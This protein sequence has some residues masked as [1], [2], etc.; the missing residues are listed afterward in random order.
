MKRIAVFVVCVAISVSSWAGN[1]EALAA[2]KMGDYANA[3]RE[4]QHMAEQGDA[5][6]QT[7]LGVMYY[8][9]DGVP[10]S[11]AD[12]L[13]WYTKAAAQ[14]YARA[15]TSLGWMYERG[16][17]VPRSYE[18]A[19]KWYAKAAEQGEVNAQTNLGGMYSLGEGVQQNSAEAVKWYTKA[20]EQGNINAQANLG[21]L[22]ETGMGNVAQDNAEAIKWYAKA[23]AQGDVKSQAKIKILHP[24]ESTNAIN[25]GFDESSRIKYPTLVVPGVPEDAI[26]AFLISWPLGISDSESSEQQ[27]VSPKVVSKITVYNENKI[28]VL[29][30][31]YCEFSLN[32]REFCFSTTLTTL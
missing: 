1:D 21:L 23:A 4:W 11:Y 31:M 10:K 9:G 14:G 6:A 15:Q 18:E 22:Y 30:Q 2:F 24:A 29:H 13:K 16:E 7:N 27:L 12:A 5:K 20:A 3:L 26:G 8:N 25:A 19:R 17:G 28:S 32:V